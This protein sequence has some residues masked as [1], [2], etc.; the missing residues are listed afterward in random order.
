MATQLLFYEMARGKSQFCNWYCS[1]CGA[2]NYITAYN[3]K[4][5]EKIIRELR[6]FC[7]FCRKTVMHRRKDTKKAA[8]AK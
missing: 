5:N 7:K 8:A 2:A 3:K 1:Q 6:K 4:S